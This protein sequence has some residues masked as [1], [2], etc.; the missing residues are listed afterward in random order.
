MSGGNTYKAKLNYKDPDSGEG[1]PIGISIQT[2]TIG[3]VGSGSDIECDGGTLTLISF[4]GSTSDTQQNPGSSEIIL[5]NNTGSTITIR[6]FE[7]RGTPLRI[8]KKITVEDVDAT[9][10]D[11]WDYIDKSIPGKYAVSDTQAHVSTQRWV[12]FGR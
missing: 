6:K 10:T 11:D 8:Q 4:N 7:V 5:K 12:E 2:P 1:F 3:A 9:V